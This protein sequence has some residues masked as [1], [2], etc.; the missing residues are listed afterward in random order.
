MFYR[1]CFG[2]TNMIQYA[3]RSGVNVLR[4]DLSSFSIIPDD[5]KLVGQFIYVF[6]K[7][8]EDEESA[9]KYRQNLHDRMSGETPIAK[10]VTVA[11][12]IGHPTLPAIQDLLIKDFVYRKAHGLAKYGVPL[13]AFDGNDPDV[14]MYQEMMDLIVYLRMKIYERLGQ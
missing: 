6:E 8:F 12:T 11:R 7:S 3:I 14:E 10:T 9:E 1:G 2:G 5:L 13:Q 4:A